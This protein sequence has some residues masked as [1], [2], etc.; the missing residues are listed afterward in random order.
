VTREGQRGSPSRQRRRRHG[1]TEPV[2]LWA[3]A[4]VFLIWCR[5]RHG[6]TEPVTPQAAGFL[7]QAKASPTPRIH[8]AGDTSQQSPWRRS[9][10]RSPTPRIH[11]AGDTLCAAR[12][13]PA[14]VSPTPRIHR[15]GDTD[16]RRLRVPRRIRRRRH[17]F[18]EP[19]TPG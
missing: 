16:Q 19:V 10:F 12:G 9:K 7:D 17:G 4:V 3:L 11:R 2:T 1:F 8:R 14:P 5:R 15:A 6:F 18:T 13:V